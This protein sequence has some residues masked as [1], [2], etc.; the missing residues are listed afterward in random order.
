VSVDEEIRKKVRKLI[1]GKRIESDHQP[2][3]L[4]IKGERQGAR[5]ERREGEAGN[6]KGYGMRK[7]A[8]SSKGN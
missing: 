4:W 1:I 7:A 3:E 2:L 5:V 8:R 6:E